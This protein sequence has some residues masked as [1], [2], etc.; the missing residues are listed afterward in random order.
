MVAIGVYS[1]TGSGARADAK[2]ASRRVQATES[3]RI[4]ATD[5]WLLT[6]P[7][8][9]HITR[10]LDL[11]DQISLAPTTHVVKRKSDKC[12]HMWMTNEKQMY[13]TQHIVHRE[14]PG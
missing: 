5:C 11:A 4:G 2:Q 10:E 7:E 8:G 14:R 9:G 13:L 1:Q 12:R 3:E 6:I